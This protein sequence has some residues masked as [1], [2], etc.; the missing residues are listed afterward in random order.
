M[1]I[2]LT[3]GNGQVGFELRRALA[4]FGEVYA[5]GRDV[6]DL[7]SADS[8][9]AA[10]RTH[11]PQ[12]ILNAAAYTA[13]D[14]AESEPDLAM[15]INGE[16][17]RILAEEALR[18]G[19]GLI[20]YSTDYVFD[21]LSAEAYRESDPVAPL[22][23]YG[24]TKLAGETGVGQSGTA[25]LIFR[26]SWIYASRGRNFLLTILKLARQRKELAIVDDQFG[27]PTPARLVAEVTAL[28]LARI[29]P[30]RK[31]DAGALADWGGIYHLSAKG[32]AS[33]FEFAS[34]ILRGVANAAV[35]K[36]I[37]TSAYP[38][39]AARPQNSVLDNTKLHERLGLSLPDW[40]L[41][42]ELCLEELGKSGER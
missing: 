20:H 40:K 33:W 7:G 11:R 32:R 39:P 29:L 36:A 37:P 31:M 8:I 28:A 23:V 17:P 35:V 5:P 41:G 13:V 18:L 24:R 21:G 19:G 25:H 4:V 34:E 1:R 2:L 9:V 27:A 14:L 26:T 15:Q 3:G 10:V 22:N 42:L 38:I 30:G 16:A 6:L 12:L